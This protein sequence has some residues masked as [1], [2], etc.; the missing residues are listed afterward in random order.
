MNA[1]SRCSRPLAA[2]D[3]DRPLGLHFGVAAT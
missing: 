3:G 1:G 2:A